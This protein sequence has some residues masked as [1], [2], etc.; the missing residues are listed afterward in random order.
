VAARL[1]SLDHVTNGVC[2]LVAIRSEQRKPK[3]SFVIA[4]RRAKSIDKIAAPQN[5]RARR[6]EVMGIIAGNLSKAGWSWG[7]SSEIDSTGRVLYTA[8]AY[9]KDCRRFTVLADERLTAF[10]ELQAA[11]HRQLELG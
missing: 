3:H 2:H 6:N 11:I 9:A 5:H 7:C 1:A 8:D 10:R 4:V